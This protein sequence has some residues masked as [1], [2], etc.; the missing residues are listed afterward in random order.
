MKKEKSE[1]INEKKDWLQI[2]KNS[3]IKFFKSFTLFEILYLVISLV[4]ITTVSIVFKCDGL[5]IAFSIVSIISV[6]MLSKG[7]FLAPIYQIVMATLYAVQAYLNSLYG[8][9]ILNML[10][11]VPIQIATMIIWAINKKK[12]QEIQIV[13]IKWKEWLC[14]FGVAIAVVSVLLT[15]CLICL[16]EQFVLKYIPQH[17]DEKSQLNLLTL[18]QFHKWQYLDKAFFHHLFCQL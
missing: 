15:M 5:S 7:V 6:F 2:T 14:I 8:D 13:N 11:L 9:A 17:F 16:F 4:T 12:N 10:I 18:R 1:E 3:L